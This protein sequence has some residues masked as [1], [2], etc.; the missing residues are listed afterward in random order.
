MLARRILRWTCAPLVGLVLT[1][2]QPRLLPAA[3]LVPGTGQALPQVGDDFEDPNWSFVH[4]HPKSSEEQ[5]EQKRTPTGKATNG[6][7]Y[8]GIKRGQPD[9]MKYVPTPEGGLAASKGSLMIRTLNSGIP[10]SYSSTM[11]QDDLI[12]NCA[13][14][15]PSPIAVGQHPSAVVRVYVPPF[16]QWEDRSGPSFGFRLSLETHAWV[17]PEE[18]RKKKNRW[19]VP[20]RP[21]FTTETYWPGLFIQFR[22][23]NESRQQADSA[24]LTIRGNQR[25][26]DIKGPE[27]TPGW[28][29]FGMSVT[30]DGQVH[31]YASPGVDNL[32]EADY[33]TSHFPYGYKAE[34]FKTFFFN[35]CNRDDG[36][37]WSTPWIID[38]PTLYVQNPGVLVQKPATVVAPRR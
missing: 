18:K 10:G 4:N 38:D 27:I 36:R 22:N 34:K 35:V 37:T 11:Q 29:T 6:R 7:W 21:E 33:I 14:R 16:D 1:W 32:T 8:E 17:V 19:G 30:G 13:Q 9:Q 26:A 2:A 12:V 15:L 5:D 3:P 23:K 28:W 20:H 25:G 31:Y 24:Y